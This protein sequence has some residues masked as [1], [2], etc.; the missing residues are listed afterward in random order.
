MNT[1]YSASPTEPIY[2]I[3]G[4]SFLSGVTD[5]L[6][7]D[8]NLSINS[9]EGRIESQQKRRGRDNLTDI[10]KTQQKFNRVQRRL[11]TNRALKS[12]P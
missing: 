6:A 2:P 10:H 9:G 8:G 4:A 7:V 12:D 5:V 1:D 3:A 11:F